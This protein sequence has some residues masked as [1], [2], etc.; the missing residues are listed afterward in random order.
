MEPSAPHPP[1]PAPRSP[2]PAGW[3]VAA[4]AAAVRKRPLAATVCGVPLVLFRG[5]DGRPAALEDRCPHRNAPLSAGRVRGGALECAYHGWRFDLDG[6]CVAVPALGRAP[7]AAAARATA[8]PCLEQDGWV[9]VAPS[10]APP[11]SPPRRL[12]FLGARGYTTVRNEL[13]VRASLYRA[14][15]NVLDVPHTAYL[16]GGLFRRSGAGQEIEVVVRRWADRCE[17]EYLGEPRPAGLVGRVLAPR[18]GVV[19]HF[20]RF[21]LPCVAEVE[22]RLGSTSHL[23]ATTA[24]TPVDAERTRLFSAVTFRLPVPGWLV[25]P[26]LFPV[27]HGILRQDARMLALQTEVVAR[28]GGERFASTEVDVLGP[29]I[30]RLLREAGHGAP[31]ATGPADAAPAHEHRVRMRP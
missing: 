16:H 27:A 1:A 10:G 3:F 21:L 13:E 31:P 24:A 19:E 26:V 15:E 2:A 23:V 4:R 7:G 6:S 12:P 29:Q 30:A 11:A 28:F 22:Y 14:V 18:G 8:F 17:A 25:A 5:A 20:D 9:W